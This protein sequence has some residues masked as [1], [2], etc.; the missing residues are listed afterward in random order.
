VADVSLYNSVFEENTYTNNSELD[1]KPSVWIKNHETAYVE[2]CTFLKQLPNDQPVIIKEGNDAPL[3]IKNSIFSGNL[4][5][6][7]PLTNANAVIDH[8]FLEGLITDELEVTECFDFPLPLF[9][10]D[11]Y[12][13]NDADTSF[14]DHG[15]P[16]EIYT[17]SIHYPIGKKTDRGDLGVSGGRYNVWDV[18]D[19]QKPLLNDY[20]RPV[21]IERYNDMCGWYKI[22][23]SLVEG[24]I[25][26]NY[27]WYVNDSI[28]TT[29]NENLLIKY[30]ADDEIIAVT[31]IAKNNST[32]IIVVGN[33]TINTYREITYSRTVLT[34]AGSDYE[35]GD[36][37]TM[38][39][40]CPSAI[41]GMYFTVQ[42]L[43]MPYFGSYEHEWNIT[44]GSGI[45]GSVITEESY[46]EITFDLE[47][48]QD[49]I[50]ERFITIEYRGY[51]YVC[52]IEL[53]ITCEI[54]FIY[55]DLTGYVEMVSIAPAET[56]LEASNP[57]IEIEFN[58]PLYYCNGATI[59]KIADGTVETSLGIV[60]IQPAAGDPVSIESLEYINSKLVIRPSMSNFPKGDYTIIVANICNACG[61]PFNGSYPVNIK[62][63][64]IDDPGPQE[65]NIWPNP[66]SE[67]V[68]IDLAG[69]KEKVKFEIYNSTGKSILEDIM[70]PGEKYELDVSEFP[71]GI[72]FIKI[73]DPV[74]RE[75]F[76][77]KLIVE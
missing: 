9:M 68:F 73:Y 23:F 5:P 17:D 57:V 67:K 16:A 77:K 53:I 72:Y 30:I 51:D 20:T 65:I 49:T 60:E 35:C 48:T 28:F 46:N 27:K 29:G 2:N 3:I 42:D 66:S 15:D 59:Y 10:P 21:I 63:V 41:T 71:Q 34:Y 70:I 7:T 69:Q 54:T 38:N 4:N 1:K 74:S 52:D 25:F 24:D 26:D 44:D 33:N 62:Y 14:I 55:S 6:Q 11:S 56:L 19:L 37:I 39:D 75:W 22:Y 8:S 13:L 32:G 45:S 58:R 18:D 61:F 43:R 76:L 47:L 40:T 31:G 50:A 36:I 64:G 12:I